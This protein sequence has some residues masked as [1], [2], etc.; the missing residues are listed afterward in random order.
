MVAAM[1]QAWVVKFERLGRHGAREFTVRA[2]AGRPLMDAILREAKKHLV[3]R[4]PDIEMAEDEDGGWSGYVASGF[5]SFPF[6][7][8]PS[9]P[10]T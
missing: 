4:H 5:H 2:E 8:R 3:T 7:A 6:A 9:E 10:R 1:K